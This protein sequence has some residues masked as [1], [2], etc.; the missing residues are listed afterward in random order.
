MG[1]QSSNTDGS[2]S[3]VAID[4]TGN[5]LMELCGN[6]PLLPT[7]T[8]ARPR[9]HVLAVWAFPASQASD[10]AALTE[11]RRLLSVLL[12]GR[13]IDFASLPVPVK[14]AAISNV[15]EKHYQAR[16]MVA[17]LRH[18]V[19]EAEIATGDIPRLLADA[20]LAY[21]VERSADL[22]RRVQREEDAKECEVWAGILRDRNFRRWADVG[23][24]RAAVSLAQEAEALASPNRQPRPVP[25]RRSAAPKGAPNVG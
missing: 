12:A 20:A 13:L 6:W 5:L 11:I 3:M 14:L 2:A 25:Q 9:E 1:Q 8:I 24:E 16:H 7:L 17:I 10:E 15:A 23:D 22:F 19:D 4:T 18:A 21:R